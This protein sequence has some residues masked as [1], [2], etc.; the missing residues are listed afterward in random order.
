MSVF[1]ASLTMM[2][3]GDSG[4][5]EWQPLNDGYSNF[6]FELTNDTLNPWLNFSKKNSNAVIDWGDGS[7]EVAL[8]TLTPT[9]TY[10]KAGKY[11][12]K[13]KGVTGIGRQVSIP[14][15]NY[16]YVYKYIELNDEVV[17]ISRSNGFSY[18]SIEKIVSHSTALLSNA[19]AGICS[20]CGAL[21]SFSV[22]LS[23]IPVSAFNSNLQLTDVPIYNATPRIE[24]NA[25]M[26]C[27]MLNNITIP[28]T[29]T[30]IGQQAFR[31][32][33]SLNTIHVQAT[34]PPTLETYV[35]DNI[36]SDYIIYV[37][38]GT[39][40]TY[41]AAEGWSTYADH[42]L[43]EGQTPNRMMLAKFGSAGLGEEDEKPD[44]EEMR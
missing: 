29:V 31:Y 19:G 24:Q 8:D 9:H 27:F 13:C 34:T 32:C 10:S 43:E 20:Y 41:K 39:G 11:V 1:N 23:T 37:P 35:F 18:T 36:A 17:S 5:S 25:F 12:V 42:I 16:S 26:N 6:W 14:L 21:K 40:D 30:T 15:N 7:G 4:S 2:N 22:P 28:S 3:Q 44:N 38:V 33:R